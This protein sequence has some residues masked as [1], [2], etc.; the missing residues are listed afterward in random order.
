MV[1]VVIDCA[2]AVDVAATILSLSLMAAAKMPLLLLPSTITAS[3]MN[4]D[5]ARGMHNNDNDDNDA[6]N[7]GRQRSLSVDDQGKDN[8]GATA[9]CLHTWLSRDIPE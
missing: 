4:D 5:G 3:T 1:V 6:I 2:A 9:S 7:A 8:C